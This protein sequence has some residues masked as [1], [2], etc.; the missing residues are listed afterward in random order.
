M[1]K[2]NEFEGEVEELENYKFLFVD[3]DGTMLTSDKQV[4]KSTLHTFEELKKI[5]VE[6]VITSGRQR[7]NCNKIAGIV[8]SGRYVISANGADVYDR[9]TGKKI[10]Q[11]TILWEDIQKINKIVD[12][13][14][15]RVRY[16]CEDTGLVNKDI[17]NPLDETLFENYDDI[18]DKDIPQVVLYFTSRETF[19][20]VKK[21]IAKISGIKVINQNKNM[22]NQKTYFMD[23]VSAGTSKGLAIKKLLKSVNI[24][25]FASVSIGDGVNDASMFEVTGVSV[26]MGNAVKKC[27]EKAQIVTSSN[28]ED[29]IYNACVNLFDIPEF[30]E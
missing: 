21:E 22:D 27:I 20:E 4:Q 19:D 1:E 13:Y 3:I 6:V 30:Y 5:G 26:A 17:L 7:S 2:I 15:L 11:N 8:G 16:V 23:V 14:N 25:R 9:E 10:Y 24:P 12:K 29:G 28:D 18:K